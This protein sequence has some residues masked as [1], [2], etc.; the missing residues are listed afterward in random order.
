MRHHVNG[1]DR[2]LTV[3]FF[4]DLDGGN[5]LHHLIGDLVGALGP[6][7]DHLVVL[8]ALRD[9]T[10]IVLLLEL[11]DQI[12]RVSSTSLPSWYRG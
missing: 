5:A 12:L 10:V 1:V 3:G 6:G 2:L 8:L 4:I 11:L 9:Q 7:I